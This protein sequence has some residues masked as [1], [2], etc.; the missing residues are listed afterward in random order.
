MK[1]RFEQ[2][3]E[4]LGSRIRILVCA[5]TTDQD[6][7]LAAIDA[8]FAECE[9]I[10]HA[11]SRFLPDSEISRLN[12][13]IGEAVEISEELFLLLRFCEQI[14]QVTGGAFDISVQSILEGWGY[15]PQYSLQEKSEGQTGTFVLDEKSRTVR[16]SAPIDLGAIG[17]GYALDRMLPCFEGF[18]DLMLDAGGDLYARGTD[19]NG[20]S[21]KIV[22]E[23]PTDVRQGIG[24]VVVDGFF[25][26]ASSPSRRKWRDRHH[27][28]HPQTK[29]P[30]HNM[31]MTYIQAQQGIIAD[32]LSTALFVLGWENAL[33]LTPSLEVEAMLIGKNGKIVRSKGFRGELFSAE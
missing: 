24:E 14:K 27:L 22:F 23:H 5:E 31:L 30:A 28:V 8:A 20:S 17:K 26:A 12:Q 19:E 18:P 9:R 33:R 7:A 3:R 13:R 1:R 32:A 16:L 29:Q 2:A 25:C 21:W 11:F 4:L 6:S 10:E 15:D